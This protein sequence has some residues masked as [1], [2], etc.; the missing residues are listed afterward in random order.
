MCS[1][2]PIDYAADSFWQPAVSHLFDGCSPASFKVAVAWLPPD[3]HLLYAERFA[4]LDSD[5]K[6]AL[7]C[8]A[9]AREDG[10]TRRELE[11]CTGAAK[12]L[13]AFYRR[14]AR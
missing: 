13:D 4:T 8:L 12:G 10:L 7:A 11:A 5:L 14:I 9:V 6:Q 2:V 3:L 1:A